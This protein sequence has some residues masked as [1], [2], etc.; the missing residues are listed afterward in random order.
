MTERMAVPV[1]RSVAL[2]IR[3]P[4]VSR[5]VSGRR[6]RRNRVTYEGR[7]GPATSERIVVERCRGRGLGC[8]RLPPGTWR[9]LGRLEALER[10]HPGATLADLLESMATEPPRLRA[11]LVLALREAVAPRRLRV[12]VE[13]HTDGDVSSKRPG[14]PDLFVFKRRADGTAYAG[15]FV[16]VKRPGERLAPHQATELRFMRDAG[17]RAG[18]LRLIE[19]ERRERGK[20]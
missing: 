11:G 16:E 13:R 3:L 2:G 7:R 17:L 15:R 10:R 18:V 4:G 5:V 8:H 14:V 6:R 12:L 19:R 20:R 1:T 9:A